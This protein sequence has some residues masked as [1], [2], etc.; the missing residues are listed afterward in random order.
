MLGIAGG[1]GALGHAVTL[2]CPT[3][4]PLT[5]RLRLPGLTVR[6]TA[7]SHGAVRS[8]WALGRATAEFL[9]HDPVDVVYLRAFPADWPIVLA[10][11]PRG[12]PIAY[13]LNTILEA[14]YDSLGKPLRAKVYRH[15]AAIALRR[16]SGWLPVTH[17]IGDWARQLSGVDR[18]TTIAI[19]G[20]TPPPP[21]LDGARERSRAE[22]GVSEGTRLIGMAG[23]IQ[24]WHGVDLAIAAL[25]RL[26][27]RYTLWLIG[28]RNEREMAAVRETASRAGV[29]DRVRIF[30]WCLHDEASRLLAACDVAFGALRIGLKRLHEA[31]EMK[32]VHALSLGVPVVIN[33]PDPRIPGP[34]SFVREVPPDDATALANAIAQL[35]E[36]ATP[37]LRAATRS[38]AEGRLSWNAAA[39]H[40]EAFLRALV[41]TRHRGPTP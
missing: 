6:P 11:L 29:G 40:T 21:E 19:N 3:A 35:A 27:A 26:P 7:S 4:L 33:H 23:F 5:P 25:A 1:L 30:P 18:P 32:I 14:E 41:S 10:G 2:I 38:Y 17:E 36:V 20:T 37:E 28:S 12:L 8:A 16:A 39:T 13:E 15:L 22:H 9:R 31:Q 34:H 24:P